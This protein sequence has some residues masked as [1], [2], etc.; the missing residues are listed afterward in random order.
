MP[1]HRWVRVAFKKRQN[2]LLLDKDRVRE[3]RSLRDY[4]LQGEDMMK[5][6]TVILLLALLVTTSGCAAL[7]VAGA[8][9]GAGIASYAYLK[10]DL[11]IEYK[12]DYEPVWD[13]TLNALRDRN[14]TVE[15]QT[16]DGI[17]G[18]IQARRASGTAVKIKVKNVASGLT[19]VTIRVGTFGDEEASMS[20][21]KAIDGYLG[22]K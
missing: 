4:G 11:V 9:A 20:I 16:K 8:G 10:G 7:L 1:G 2:L 3:H 6:I 5:G 13:A 18:S 15:R 22:V 14:I 21:K 17:S 12:R 19:E